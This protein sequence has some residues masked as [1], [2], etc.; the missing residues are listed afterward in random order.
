MGNPGCSERCRGVP[1]ASWPDAVVRRIPGAPTLAGRARA[2]PCTRP[3][4]CR[5]RPS[6]PARS[7]AAGSASG[8]RRQASA[9]PPSSLHPA[10]GFARGARIPL[11]RARGAS[12]HG[13]SA[14]SCACTGVSERGGVTGRGPGSLL[15]SSAPPGPAPLAPEGPPVPG[16]SRRVGDPRPLGDG[17]A[18][19]RRT[20]FPTRGCVTG[21]TR[22]RPAWIEPGPADSAGPECRP[23]A[24][25]V[26]DTLAAAPPPRSLRGA[27]GVRA[28]SDPP[29]PDRDSSGCQR[30]ERRR[31]AC[32]EGCASAALLLP[33]SQG[34]LNA[35]TPDCTFLFD[36]LFLE[37]PVLRLDRTPAQPVFHRGF[38][39][40]F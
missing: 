16:R 35:G 24:R 3:R 27:R 1:A 8:C 36:T 13:A 23:E 21:E 2:S 12:Q 6:A 14:R 4:R 32:A 34:K 22:S 7:R 33:H 19:S 31:R 11:T 9:G 15:A 29:R 37:V 18:H 10:R 39:S 30:D 26:N 17:R 38:P 20:T 40:R 5:C 28:A 25:R